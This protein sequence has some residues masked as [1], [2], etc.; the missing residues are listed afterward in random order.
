MKSFFL[1]IFYI[2]KG[3]LESIAA[4][5][6]GII[7]MALHG[8]VGDKGKI[9]EDSGW[10]TTDNFLSKW[11]QNFVLSV[12]ESFKKAGLP[13]E[14]MSESIRKFFGGKEKDQNSG[15]PARQEKDAPGAR[16][17][18]DAQDA[19]Q[20]DATEPEKKEPPND[21]IGKKADE[22]PTNWQDK[23]K[24]RVVDPQDQIQL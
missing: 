15:S 9:G 22:P 13:V 21:D 19:R 1:C 14:D 3:L 11:S 24:E 7:N 16:Q 20:E 2:V 8:I 12:M 18:K 6:L 17:E 4:L 5:A 10:K 23:M